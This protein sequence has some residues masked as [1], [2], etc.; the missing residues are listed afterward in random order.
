MV[1]YTRSIRSYTQNKNAVEGE[2][3]NVVMFEYIIKRRSG[4]SIGAV[5]RTTHSLCSGRTPKSHRATFLPRCN[6]F[7]KGLPIHRHV[8]GTWASTDVVRV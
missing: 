4:G 5:K 6:F 7:S 8:I 1:V 3:H 2:I